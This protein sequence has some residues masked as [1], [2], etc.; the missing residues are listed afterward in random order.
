MDAVSVEM[1]PEAYAVTFVSGPQ[2]ILHTLC[3]ALCYRN[4]LLALC[5]LDVLVL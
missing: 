4:I 3:Q 5:L 2:T 1:H